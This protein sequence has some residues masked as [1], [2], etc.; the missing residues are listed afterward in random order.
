MPET[1]SKHFPSQ[2][3]DTA[4]EDFGCCCSAEE[5]TTTT[6]AELLKTTGVVRLLEEIAGIVA[7]ESTGTVALDAGGRV[8]AEEAGIAGAT[9]SRVTTGRFAVL[10]SK[11][12]VPSNVVAVPTKAPVSSWVKVT[13]ATVWPLISVTIP[14]G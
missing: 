14:A 6:V 10:I 9:C 4:A 12:G 2:L 7:L 5:L 11:T 1:L 8:V 13:L 3:P